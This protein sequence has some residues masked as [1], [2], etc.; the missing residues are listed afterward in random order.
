MTGNY[1]VAQFDNLR[2]DDDDRPIGTTSTDPGE[3]TLT[4]DFL[5]LTLTGTDNDLTVNGV[6]D[7]GVL[8]GTVSYDGLDGNLVGEIGPSA[9]VG[10]FSGSDANTV[11]AGGFHVEE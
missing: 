10:S 5:A 2:L 9:A 11:F 7:D 8:S 6:M 1:E 4:A 3:I